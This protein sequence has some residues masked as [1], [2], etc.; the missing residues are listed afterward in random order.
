MRR[1]IL[2]SKKRISITLAIVFG[3]IAI[4]SGIVHPVRAA[5]EDMTYEMYKAN[6]YIDYSPYEYYMSDEF[7]LPYRTQVEKN[8]E[9]AT[10]NALL[11]AWQLATFEITDV[12]EYSTRKV[13]YY[14]SFLYDI[15][16][17]GYEATNVSK[18]L[19]NSV[20]SIEA[21]TL[22][23]ISS[24]VGADLK[25]YRD[26]NI[27]EFTVEDREAFLE[28]FDSCEELSNAVK[29]LGDLTKVLD[30][31]STVEEVIYKLAKIEVISRLSV[32]NAEVL[33]K[34]AANTDDK[35]MQAACYEMAE[36][37]RG[38]LTT[39]Q[40]AL[41][42]GSEATI[43]EMADMALDGLWTEVTNKMNVYGLAVSAGQAAGKW[44]GGLFLSGDKE[45]ET[46]YE[47]C[48]L[49]DFENELREVVK[50]YEKAYT[51]N[52][53]EA[54]AKLYNTS[55]EMLLQTMQLACDISI[56]YSG[57][58]Y[59]DEGAPIGLFISYVTGNHE[60]YEKF[61]ETL[62]NIKEQIIWL[63]DFAN[64]DIYALYCDEYCEDAVEVLDMQ[65]EP[66]DVTATEVEIT[67][68]DLQQN[69]FS[70]SDVHIT[71]DYTLTEDMETYCNLYIEEGKVDL[72]GHKLTVQG[73]VLQSGGMLYVNGGEMDVVG[74]YYIAGSRE[75]GDDGEEDV[76]STSVSD[77][78]YLEM[79]KDA[80]IVR[81][82]GD[83][84]TYSYENHSDYLT[85]GTLYVGGNF[86]QR[87]RS[88]NMSAENFNATED[89]KVVFNGTGK[90]KITFERTSSGFATVEFQNPNIEIASAIRGFE[91]GQDIN[92][93]ISADEFGIDG[94][95]KLNGHSLGSG[96]INTGDQ[97]TFTEGIWD[98]GG[99]TVQI[100]N[101]L[102]QS[103]GTIYLNGG[104]MNVPGDYYIAGSREMGDDGEEDVTS[105]SVSDNA[106]LEMVKD[107]DIVRVGGDFLTYS[108]ENHSDY[109]TA[110]TL[111]VGGNFTQRYRSNNMSAE[112][113]NATEGH[114]VVFNGTGKQ[115]ITFERTSSGFATVEFQNPNIEI[116]SAIRG[117]ELGQDINLTISA[118]EFGIDGTWKLNGHSLGSGAINTG[119]QFTFTEGIW[120]FGGSTVQI[121]NDLLQSG[122]TIYLNGGKMN[123][124]GDYYI[125]GSREMGDDGEEDVTSTSV[126]D[127]AYLEMVK[128]ADIVRVGGDFLTYSYENHS[129]YL[130]AG[131]LYVGG[132]FTQRYRSNNMSAENFNATEGHKVVFNGTGKQKITFERTSSG[133]ATVE[134]QNPNIEIASAIR[135]FELGQ[136]IN[137]TISADEFGIDGTWKLK[138]HSLGSGAI[139]TGDQ[140]TF[141]EGIWD[142]GG[143]TVQIKNNLLQ[144][145]GTIYLNG[146]KLNVPGDY[147]IAGSRSIGDDGEEDV[148]QTSSSKDAYL[149]MVKD[150]DEV[151]V[152]GDFLTY[153]YENHSD[154]LTAGT[155]YIGGDF[156]QKSG[157]SY[158]FAASGTH[159]VVLNSES[160]QNVV[161]ESDSSHFNNLKL[162]K[163]RNNYTC[164]PENCWNKL[165]SDQISEE[166]VVT[167]VR[168]TPNSLQLLA[169]EKQ[170]LTAV[171][172][173]TNHPS[174]EVTWILSGNNSAQTTVDSNGVL[175]IARDET[176]ATVIVTA[177]S[178]EDNKK[179]ASLTVIIRQPEEDD[180]GTTEDDPS[181]PS[182]DV[183]Q[184]VSP[185]D[186]EQPAPSDDTE[187]P[188]ENNPSVKP[189]ETIEDN[190]DSQESVKPGESDSSDLPASG[191]TITDEETNADYQV[192][193]QGKTVVYKKV[194]NV[195]V[196]NVTIPS[197]VNINGITYNVTNIANNAFSKCKKIKK[198]IISNNITVIGNGAFNKCTSLKRIV[199]PAKVTSIGK[200]AFSGCK[201]LKNIIVKSKKLKKIGKNAFKGINKT[202]KIKVPKNKLKAYKKL[203][204]KA[205]LAKSIKV[206]K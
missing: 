55:F 153:S 78:A 5:E 156:T 79:V 22:K 158:N 98:F 64:K 141:T 106:Y 88:N 45:V 167:G 42:L 104:K 39:E 41:L 190:K 122:G 124:P 128:D 169:G 59:D 57:I 140:F 8:R 159:T 19:S 56:E 81:V 51:S 180:T 143:S 15:L 188:E 145:G 7:T 138:G 87:Y 162:T 40:M 151:R 148:T 97:F 33:E 11:I 101:D 85:A 176:A 102:L 46:F 68:D 195:N 204:K 61:K 194:L 172:E 171:V 27:E 52:K 1:I 183:E 99:S 50:S 202:A 200:N 72:N 70:S 131:T 110:G 178:V 30:Y 90:Q 187:Q 86:T 164:N 163:D 60:K 91:L 54:N 20:K 105:T 113:F 4:I 118:D 185:D 157:S 109:L 135:G 43:K 6:Y 76:T 123:V 146:G 126:S 199:I 58:T 116:A 152:G 96:A 24:F 2:K 129:D 147:Y 201:N 75:M 181:K 125:A 83:F 23:K 189:G 197:V 112:N 120:D 154:Y 53:T 142:F 16:Y 26:A 37:C 107:A 100:K 34:I 13:G 177:Q 149:E 205:K 77:D 44:V 71:S 47:M 25:E 82:G 69:V 31:A 130:T 63:Q 134:F 10:Y 127:N 84:L 184:P 62:T 179:T 144:T 103:G 32:E 14:E 121:K 166:P 80:D 35:A 3:M 28:I 186:T 139:N 38:N 191:T 9:S 48:A 203:F 165:I 170:Q 119:D 49:Y 17:T 21:S 74:D 182:D 36:I 89:H 92:L 168:I 133:F 173:G 95:W 117:F 67:L 12:N 136:D 29:G 137:L 193:E 174:Q 175:S 198:I 161:F 108:Y 155:M 206:T 150:A 160:K 94:T 114:K 65:P 115:K 196:V 132:N 73:D 192:V 93:T 111:Y 18:T 66:N